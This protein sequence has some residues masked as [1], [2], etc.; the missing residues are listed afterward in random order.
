MKIKWENTEISNL[1]DLIEKTDSHYFW[2]EPKPG[3]VT[4]NRFASK[5]DVKSLAG[6][7]KPDITDNILEMR[8]FTKDGGIHIVKNA[9][10]YKVAKFIIGNEGEEVTEKP[11]KR[12]LNGK[13]Q[14]IIVYYDTKAQPV[15]WKIDI[16]QGGSNE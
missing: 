2:I 3:V 12:I 13:Q 6:D 14:D 8:L 7:G 10:A 9:K 1:A 16:T 11:A 4:E 15:A 5:C